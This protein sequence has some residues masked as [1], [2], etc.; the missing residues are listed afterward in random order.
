MGIGMDTAAIVG[1]GMAEVAT[2]P[3]AAVL[4]FS[5]CVPSFCRRRTCSDF[6]FKGRERSEARRGGALGAREIKARE[7]SYYAGESADVIDLISCAL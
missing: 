1:S 7:T 4:R 2:G 5:S 3:T 6:N